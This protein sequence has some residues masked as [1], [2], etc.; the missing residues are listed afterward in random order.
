MKKLRLEIEELSVESFATAASRSGAGTVRA[1]D[2]TTGHQIIC[3]CTDAGGG[4]ASAGCGS[5]G[6]AS[7]GCGSAGCATGTCTNYVTCATGNQINC[8]C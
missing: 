4:C 6:C 8:E 3:G 5:A 7:A 1:F 2:S